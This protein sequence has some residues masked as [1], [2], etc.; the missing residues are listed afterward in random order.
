MAARRRSPASTRSR[1]RQ[2]FAWTTPFWSH[3]CTAKASVTVWVRE[4]VSCNAS[5]RRPIGRGVPEY[6]LH[7]RAVDL[8]DKRTF[9][10][11]RIKIIVLATGYLATWPAN[12]AYP[13]CLPETRF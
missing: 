12:R 5:E 1:P 10:K 7:R 13:P 8:H 11:G 4:S 6:L 3:A 9:L 2:Q